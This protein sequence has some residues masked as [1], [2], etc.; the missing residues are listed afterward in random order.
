MAAAV[1]T[2]EATLPRRVGFADEISGAKIRCLVRE[3]W[4]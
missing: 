1:G 4:R 3:A 2:I